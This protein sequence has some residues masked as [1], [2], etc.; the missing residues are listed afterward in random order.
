MFKSFRSLREILPT[1][2]QSGYKRLGYSPAKTPRMQSS[3]F[4][5]F[6]GALCA[7]ARVNPI[8][9]AP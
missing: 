5:F 8:L 2:F 1:A 4:V 9:V 6:L 7:F 3:D